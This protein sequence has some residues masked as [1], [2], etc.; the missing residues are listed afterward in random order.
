MYEE[1]SSCTVM[2]W[3]GRELK[4]FSMGGSSIGMVAIVLEVG[5]A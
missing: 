2:F 4:G 5:H 1:S 3:F